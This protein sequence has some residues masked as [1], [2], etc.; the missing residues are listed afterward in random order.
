MAELDEDEKNALSHR[1]RAARALGER[2]AAW[3]GA[4]S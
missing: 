1:G 4:R 2:L 3:L